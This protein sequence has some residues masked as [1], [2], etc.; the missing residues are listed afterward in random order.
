[1]GVAVI[2]H[3][4]RSLLF[5]ISGGGRWGGLRHPTEQER[6]MMK[7]LGFDYIIS[8]MCAISIII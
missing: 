3:R 5:F 8:N 7:K 2:A 6:K 4:F 1:M